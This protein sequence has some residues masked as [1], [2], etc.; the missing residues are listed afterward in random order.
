[1]AGDFTDFT[2]T[3]F[4][5]LKETF[6]LGEFRFLAG[7]RDFER[8]FFKAAFFLAAGDFDRDRDRERDRDFERFAFRRR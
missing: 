3:D 2:F 6:F 4:F 8:D 1:L 5:S 7:E